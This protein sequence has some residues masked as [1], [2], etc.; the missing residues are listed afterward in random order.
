M[1]DEQS[2]YTVTVKGKRRKRT[3]FKTR[4]KLTL[5]D[6]GLVEQAVQEFMKGTRKS[7]YNSHMVGFTL[8]RESLL[9]EPETLAHEIGRINR[10]A[11]LLLPDLSRMRDMQFSVVAY[12]RLLAEE[13]HRDET[14]AILDSI[15]LPALQIGSSAD[16][17]ISLLVARAILAG[18]LE[19]SAHIYESLGLENAAAQARVE[20]QDERQR[21]EDLRAGGPETLGGE[22]LKEHGG[23]FLSLLTPTHTLRNPEML[24]SW[25]HLERVLFQ[26]AVLTIVFLFAM[27][28]L[29]VLLLRTLGMLTAFR[30]ADESPKLFF[31]GWKR[32]ACVVGVSVMLPLALYYA[33]TRWTPFGGLR[34]GINFRPERLFLEL[35]IVGVAMTLLSVVTTYRAIRLR[36]K[37]ARGWPCL[38]QASCDPAGSGKLRRGFAS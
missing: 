15:R 35:L 38:R 1:E 21:V 13:G 36:C 28:I 26:R 25:R 2:T 6:R 24:R 29:L 10:M 5:K 4:F 19:E 34:Y 8:L 14:L 31:V 17:L 12:A 33:Y 11:G 20:A 16:T 3:R 9:R 30:Q 23:V 22:E 32:L 37:D 27:L 18:S 7:A